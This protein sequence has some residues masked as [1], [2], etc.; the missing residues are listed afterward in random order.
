MGR[1]LSTLQDLKKIELPQ[2]DAGGRLS[3]EIE[4]RGSKTGMWPVCITLWKDRKKIGG[5][6]ARMWDLKC[7]VIEL[8]KKKIQR[9]A[10]QL[11]KESAPEWGF[12][13]EDVYISPP[14]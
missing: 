6:G 8:N 11:L 14:R 13:F 12:E 3:W 7:A 4:L 1:A 10:W 9:R 2:L 5:H